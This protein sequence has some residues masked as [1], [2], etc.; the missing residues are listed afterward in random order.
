[1]VLREHKKKDPTKIIW[2]KEK[3][4]KMKNLNITQIQLPISKN[5]ISLYHADILQIIYTK[6]KR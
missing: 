4:K 5:F 6:V 1:M 3:L 2:N